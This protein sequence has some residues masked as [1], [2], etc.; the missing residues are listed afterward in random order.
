LLTGAG[1]S[2]DQIVAY[3]RSGPPAAVGYLALKEAGFD[4][5]LFDGSYAEWTAHGLPAEK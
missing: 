2:G 1:I 3:C 5:K 4:V